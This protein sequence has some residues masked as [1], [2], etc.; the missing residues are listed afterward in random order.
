V[1]IHSLRAAR[2]G[3]ATL[4]FG[5][6]FAYA[7]WLAR[8]PAVRDHLQ[9][10]DR[11][12]GLLLL[13]SGIGALVAF[14]MASFFLR[15]FDSRVVAA[16]GCAVFGQL[17]FVPAW[18]PHPLVAAVALFVAGWFNG[19]MDVAINS[20]AVD[21]EHRLQKPILASLHGFFSLGGLAGASCGALAAALDISPPVHLF[22]V[23]FLQALGSWWAGTNLLPDEVRYGAPKGEKKTKP[24]RALYFLGSIAFCSAVG[25]GGM[26]EW[27]AIYMRDALHTSMGMAGVGYALFSLA[28]VISRLV[29]DGLTR[30]TQPTVLLARSGTLAAVGLAFGLAFQTPWTFCLGLLATGMGLAMVVPVV[31]R[32]A[33]RVPNVRAAQALSKIST[34]GYCGFLFGPPLIGL[35]SESFSLRSGLFLIVLMSAGI[36]LLARY[37]HAKLA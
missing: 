18:T 37:A 15:V 35:W 25:E 28:M 4:F 29:G 9:L 36:A 16:V 24:P 11:Q 26:A 19:L 30:A 23:G 1:D 7:N 6:G 27:T 2:R 31:L 33:I 20:Q 5:L 22:A 13:S 8:M 34:I 17:L 14:R 12:L 10:N 3:V 32:L 21:V